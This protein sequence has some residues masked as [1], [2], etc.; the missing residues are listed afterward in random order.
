MTKT[1]TGR[2][3]KTV[4]LKEQT[5]RQ[6]LAETWTCTATPGPEGGIVAADA[7]RLGIEGFEAHRAVLIAGAL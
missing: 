7:S 4:N 6:S 5:A 2:A 3:F 1:A